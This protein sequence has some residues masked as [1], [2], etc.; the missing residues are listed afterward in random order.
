MNAITRKVLKNIRHRDEI[1]KFSPE[2]L[3]ERHKKRM[4]TAK[5]HLDGQHGLVDGVDVVR[6]RVHGL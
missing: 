6:G 4:E 1:G 5:G 2:E 3:V